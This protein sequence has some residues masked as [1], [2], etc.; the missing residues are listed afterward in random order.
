MVV[1]MWYLME[2]LLAWASGPKMELGRICVFACY[3][4]VWSSN[5]EVGD[6]WG[7]EPGGEYFL[8]GRRLL[9]LAVLLKARA[10]PGFWR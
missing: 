8:E 10:R 6:Q 5:S 9:L 3:W 2:L 7:E 1:G 4:D